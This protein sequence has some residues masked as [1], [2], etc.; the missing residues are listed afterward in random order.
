MAATVQIFSK[1]LEDTRG[2][3]TDL[4][5]KISDTSKELDK[6]RAALV[7]NTQKT[8]ELAAAKI[9]ASD[10]AYATVSRNI[11]EEIAKLEGQR[12]AG[13]INDR[14]YTANFTK[15]QGEQVD[16]RRKRDSD[17]D[18]LN[19]A[20]DQDVDEQEKKANEQINATIHRLD[21]EMKA[22]RDAADEEERLLKEQAKLQDDFAEKEITADIARK[23][24]FKD[25]VEAYGQIADAANKGLGI[26]SQKLDELAKKAG[27]TTQ[28]VKD[29][30]Q[31]IASF[32]PGTESG[33]ATPQTPGGIPVTPGGI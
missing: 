1:A 18:A 4:V 22:R 2:A 28:A 31:A 8:R 6:E 26:A 19:A 10:E 20:A 15:L 11:D 13:E 3:L 7:E 27:I 33:S 17:I 30:Y 14:E 32:T 25:H 9:K 16:A 29:L 21:Q 23:G 24:R 5:G 12:R